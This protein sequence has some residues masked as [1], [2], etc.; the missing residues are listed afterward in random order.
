MFNTV[1]AARGALLTGLL[2]GALA[3]AA[4]GSDDG[5]SSASSSGGGGDKG[6]IG[7]SVPTVQGPFFTAMLYGMKDEAKKLGYDL[8]IRD[9]GGYPNVDTQA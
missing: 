2:V 1:R 4:C 7:V 5:N 8:Q 3:L 6:K 9:A